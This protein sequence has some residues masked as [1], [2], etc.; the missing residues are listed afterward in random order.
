[1]DVYIN[2]LRRKLKDPPPG[3]LIRTVRGQGYLVPA[4]TDLALAAIP[5]LPVSASIPAAFTPAS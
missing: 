5:V 4:E 2:Y 1:V 3:H